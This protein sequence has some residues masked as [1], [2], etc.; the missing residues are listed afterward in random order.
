MRAGRGESTSTRS[1]RRTASTT[2]W[3]TSSVVGRRAARTSSNRSPRRSRVI[4]SRLAN[5]SSRNSSCRLGDQRAG[6]RRALAHPAREL[7]GVA[8][9]AVGETDLGQHRRQQRRAVTAARRRPTRPGSPTFSR[10]VQPG[11]QAVILGQPAD[12]PAGSRDGWGRAGQRDVPRVGWIRPLMMRSKVDL[13]QP[14]GPSS[15]TRSPG[16]TRRSI[17]IDR[18][19]R[20]CRS[21]P[22]NVW[23]MPRRLDGRAAIRR[24]DRAHASGTRALGRRS[25]PDQVAVAVD[26][27]QDPVGE[28]GVDVDGLAEAAVRQQRIVERLPLL[29]RRDQPMPYSRVTGPSAMSSSTLSI[30][31]WWLAL[32][33]R[34]ELH[35]DVGGGLGV[36]LWRPGC[37][38]ASPSGSA[39]GRPGRCPRAAGGSGRSGRATA[40]RSR[41]GGTAGSGRR[42]AGACPA[43][44]TRRRGRH[45][46]CR[47]QD[48]RVEADR[49]F[50]DL[51][52]DRRRSWRA[53]PDSPVS[54]AP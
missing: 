34:R 6:Q 25:R 50:L 3:V 7:V 24:S 2:L 8:A 44:S 35:H 37:R 11:Q 39:R 14:L 40:R 9:G 20:P 28:R 10:H 41:S 21:R 27:L 51:R 47:R 38:A 1:A 43:R 46:S 42:G 22:E 33:V 54:G 53:S 49:H 52:A 23:P 15:A 45:R 29:G 26:G 30:A 19:R 31:S 48:A 5:G 4:S 18:R 16:A 13:P 17:A 36:R 32:L 12:T